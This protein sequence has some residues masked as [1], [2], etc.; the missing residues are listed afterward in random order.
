MTKSSDREINYSKSYNY[1]SLGIALK[2]V[3]GFIV[4]FGFLYIHYVDVHTGSGNLSQIKSLRQTFFGISIYNFIFNYLDIIVLTFT[5]VIFQK[6][7]RVRI[8]ISP[9]FLTIRGPNMLFHKQHQP[10]SEV[11]IIN[12]SK[13][14]LL[15]LISY[16]KIH[17]SRSFPKYDCLVASIKRNIV[18]S[19]KTTQMSQEGLLYARERYVTALFGYF[20]RRISCLIPGFRRKSPTLNIKVA[21]VII[22]IGKVFLLT[23]EIIDQQQIE[24][25]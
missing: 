21:P 19:Q 10:W 4:F 7:L 14:G 25:L 17:I 18:V 6:W 1:R 24:Y 12:E 16:K 9:T 13:N 15:L 2:W 22:L 11:S 20:S 23:Y 3:I 8:N 5:L